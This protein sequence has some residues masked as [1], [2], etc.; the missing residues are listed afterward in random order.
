MDRRKVMLATGMLAAYPDGRYLRVEGT[1]FATPIVSA[2]A[3]LIRSKYPSMS[4]ANVVERL[5]ASAVDIGVAG[6]DNR[7]GFG[8]VNPVGALQESFAEVTANPLDNT[9]PP[10]G[11]AGFGPAAVPMLTPDGPAGQ[12]E[13]GPSSSGRASSGSGSATRDGS[14]PPV[15]ASCPSG[16][17]PD[18]P[19]PD[20]ATRPAPGNSLRGNTGGFMGAGR[21]AGG[22]PGGRRWR[23]F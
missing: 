23:P 18:P 7:Y 1:S 21:V 3:A 2:T 9:D 4:A 13:T 14:S 17:P 10:P 5:T 20:P 16:G 6:R 8:I 15:L 22:W 19:P 11:L 12:P